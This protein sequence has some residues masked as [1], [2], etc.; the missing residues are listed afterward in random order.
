M[1][2]EDL[3]VTYHLLNKKNKKELLSFCL[4]NLIKIEALRDE[5]RRLRTNHKV[6]KKREHD[7]YS[8]F[9]LFLGS[10]FE[11][12]KRPTL[13]EWNS[14]VGSSEIK[15]EY[16]SMKVKVSDKEDL[17]NNGLTK[18]RAKGWYYKFTKVTELFLK[19][20]LDN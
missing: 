11:K 5:V 12:E 2:D 3:I 18:S 14:I 8:A 15:W 10:L 19:Q 16:E 9:K 6:G 17:L 4:I 13:A 1:T 20:K 7:E